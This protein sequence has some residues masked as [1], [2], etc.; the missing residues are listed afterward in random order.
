MMEGDLISKYISRFETAYAHIYS[1]CANSS[2]PKAVALRN[3]LSV[4]QVKI[5]YLFLSLPSSYNNI[6]DNLTTKEVLRYS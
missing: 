3:F 6:I 1:R 5:M 2:R 4:K